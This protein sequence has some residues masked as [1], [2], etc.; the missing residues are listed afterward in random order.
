MIAVAEQ[1]AIDAAALMPD[2]DH[3]IR[4]EGLT[5]RYGRTFAVKELS[6]HVPKGSVYAFVGTNGAGKTTTI[7]TLATLQKPDG[8]TVRVNGIDV[9]R[10]PRTVRH[11]IG[12]MPD[13][14]G[15]YEK[16]TVSEYLDFYG[17]SYRIA[18]EQR[19]RLREEL[20]EL[21]DLED[22][23]EEQVSVLSRGM[24]QRLGLA[25]CLI[26][27]PDVLLLD[28]PASGMD[29]RSRIELRAMLAELSNLGKTILISSAILPE[30]A[31]M[32]THIGIIRA[33]EMVVEGPVQEVVER[34]TGIP[35]LRISLL[36]SSQ[37]DQ[38]R[39]V[40][41]SFLGHTVP[42]PEDGRLYLSVPFAG[43][44]GDVAPLLARLV[45]SGVS[46]SGFGLEAGTLEELFVNVT[47]GAKGEP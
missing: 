33:G 26:H 44:P 30:L 8:G 4:I 12:Y 6:M 19:R 7:R 43:G 24:K 15:V 18:A 3:A 35:R 34:F 20:L 47:E 40:V 25:R 28:E 39:A 29:P 21:V 10:H 5:K 9:L 27:D 31:G 14:F 37:L 42:D 13:T 32:C 45:Q 22:K 2:E 11:C 17:A 16:L 1:P 23:R 36:D 46:M 38:A 41:S